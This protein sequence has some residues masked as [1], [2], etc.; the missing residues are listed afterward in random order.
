[1]FEDIYVTVQLPVTARRNLAKLGPGLL[2]DICN[3]RD[4][5]SLEVP[6]KSTTVRSL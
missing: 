4:Y 2:I 5:I 6:M 3:S 1:M